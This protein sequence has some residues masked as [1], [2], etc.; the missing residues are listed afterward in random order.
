MKPGGGLL[1]RIIIIGGGLILLLVIFVVVKGLLSGGSNLPMIANIAARQQELIFITNAASTS[2]D[3]TTATK[4]AVLTT[5]LALISEQKDILAYLA[6]Q[7]F[8][9][10]PNQLAAYST[11]GTVAQLATAKQVSTY[12]TTLKQILQTKLSAYQSALAQTYDK[13][14]GEK[15]RALIKSTY[16]GS[17]LLNKQLAK[18]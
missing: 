14:T 16:A 15:G 9:V 1:M 8:K 6:K 17:I 11:S 12:E 7:G 3:L 4:S 18:Q 10:T 2:Q 13:T 5:N